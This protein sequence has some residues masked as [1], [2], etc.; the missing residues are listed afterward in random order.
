MSRAERQV[1]VCTAVEAVFEKRA[2]WNLMRLASVHERTAMRCKQ[3]QCL[4]SCI[5][6]GDAC[7]GTIYGKISRVK[8]RPKQHQ[9]CYMK[10]ST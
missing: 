1:L 3:L 10:R 8:L 7:N 4:A 2:S 6:S 9:H 5:T